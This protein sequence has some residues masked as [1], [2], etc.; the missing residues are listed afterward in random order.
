VSPNKPVT[1]IDD[2]KKARV[3]ANASGS[4]DASGKVDVGAK[5]LRP[6]DLE[7]IGPLKEIDAAKASNW[8]K[9]DGS[10]WWPPNNGALPGTEKIVTLQKCVKFGRIGGDGGSYVAPP[11]TPP[12]K[13]ALK[14]GTD[15]SIYNGYKVIIDISEVQ[16]A[17]IAKWF[18]MPGRGIQYKLP[19]SINDLIDGGYIE[20]MIK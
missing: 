3:T 6:G 2:S 9:P 10:I 12:D 1:P 17:E 16:Q 4:G 11:N 7:F 8:T 19:A 13:L 5:T 20:L 15:M 18:D 14:P